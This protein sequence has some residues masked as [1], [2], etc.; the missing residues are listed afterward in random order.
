[1]FSKKNVITIAALS[2]VALILVAFIATNLIRGHRR[3]VEDQR[4]AVLV[5]DATVQ[6]RQALG[7][8]PSTASVAKL[9]E[10]L[11]TA[12]TSPNPVLGGAAEHYLLGAREI[13]RHRAESERLAHDA[14]AARNALAAHMGRSANRSSG[15]IKGA[16]DLKRRVEASHAELARSLKTLDDL[17]GGLPDAE[18]RL[19]P[20]VAASAL[21]E[22]GEIDAARARAQD[23]SKRAASELEKV[24]RVVP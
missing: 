20:H 4:I 23:E 13:A 14:T 18:K 2:V 16:T 11:Q 10:Y 19:A 15:W 3:Q 21:L 22:A 8:S 24:R 6:L 12:K 9:E 5:A 17:L 7:S 1:M